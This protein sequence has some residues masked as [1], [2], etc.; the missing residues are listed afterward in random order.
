MAL[1]Q[2][3]ATPHR[4]QSLMPES[5][6]P[7]PRMLLINKYPNRRYY[8]TTRS[9]DISLKQIHQAI[10]EGWDV[11]VVDAKTKQDITSQVL[12]QI[13]LEYE[14]LKLTQFSNELLTQ[15]IRVKDEILKDFVD[16]YFRKAFE[17]FCVSQKQ[18]DQFLRQTHQLQ[19]VLPKPGLWP[20]NFFSPWMPGPQ[21]ATPP[22]ADRSPPVEP[23]PSPRKN[24]KKKKRAAPVDK[25]IAALR[26]EISALKGQLSTGGARKSR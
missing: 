11:T 2:P 24:N 23:P 20:G 25:E 12:T 22:Q 5:N 10:M 18:V 17:A 1:S 8:D 3:E 14:P 4:H 6:H 21:P 7:E 15:T 9:K 13:L 26:K 16:L 19:S